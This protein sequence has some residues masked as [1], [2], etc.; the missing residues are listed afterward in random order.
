MPVLLFI[1]III[2]IITRNFVCSG[3]G[4]QS[5]DADAVFV[6]YWKL[7]VLY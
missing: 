7:L 6:F 3:R 5:S 1:I 2:I 4:T